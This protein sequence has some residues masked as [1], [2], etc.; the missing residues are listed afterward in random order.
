[1]GFRKDVPEQLA[2]FDVFV[3]STKTEGFGIS[4]LEAMA[5]GVPVVASRVGGV[6]EIVKDGKN[7]LLFKIGNVQELA[8][9]IMLLIQNI[10]LKDELLANALETV[11][12]K[13]SHNKMITKYKSLYIK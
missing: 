8:G 3:L 7:G 13:F 11:S 9:A 5:S 1:M 2:K 6:P 4:I 12:I 10:V